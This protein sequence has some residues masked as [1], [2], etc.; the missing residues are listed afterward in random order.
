MPFCWI[1]NNFERTGLLAFWNYSIPIFDT[2]VLR[3]W[4]KPIQFPL[5]KLSA[6]SQK[7]TTVSCRFNDRKERMNQI[8]KK[9]KVPTQFNLGSV[10]S[11]KLAG[12]YRKTHP[13]A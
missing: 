2:T 5:S 7:S 8:G 10:G 13:M 11:E 1:K 3:N 9:E 12:P 4:M 6:T